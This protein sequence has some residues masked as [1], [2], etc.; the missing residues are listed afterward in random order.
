MTGTG[1]VWCRRRWHQTAPWQG[2]GRLCLVTDE[3]ISSSSMTKT[4]RK[5]VI[6]ATHAHFSQ[7]SEKI[8]AEAEETKAPKQQPRHVS[9]HVEELEAQAKKVERLK[10]QPSH[11]SQ[12]ARG[13]PSAGR[14]GYAAS[15]AQ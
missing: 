6:S 12:Q 7:Q 5:A 9:K 2:G 14:R 8:Q 11:I 13:D 10:Q 1:L 3:A 4:Q 15:V